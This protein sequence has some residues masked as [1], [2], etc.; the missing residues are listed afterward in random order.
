MFYETNIDWATTGNIL[1]LFYLTCAALSIATVILYA[2]LY[3][4][5]P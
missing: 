2:A 4:L 5:A 3:F 1:I